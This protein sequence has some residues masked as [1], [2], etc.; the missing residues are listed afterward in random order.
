VADVT[1]R[2]GGN[3]AVDGWTLTWTF[4]GNQRITNMWNAVPTQTGQAVSA[5]DGG[6]NRVI[7]AGGTAAFGFQA[8]FSGANAVPTAFRLNGTA[9]T[10][11]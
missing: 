10:T 8:S 4:G 11:A 7:P 3:A 9:C 5:A 1:V 6:W 2:N